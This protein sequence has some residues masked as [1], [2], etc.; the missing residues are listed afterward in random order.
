[1]TTASQNTRLTCAQI[2]G[3]SRAVKLWRD[4]WQ[5]IE[6][7]SPANLVKLC[8]KEVECMAADTPCVAHVRIAW[9]EQLTTK[10][11]ATFLM[12]INEDSG[13]RQKM[14][15]EQIDDY[16]RILTHEYGYLKPQEFM[17]FFLRFKAGYYGEFYDSVDPN[18][19]MK[20]FHR[21]MEWRRDL[22]GKAEAERTRRERQRQ[23]QA[24][25]AAKVTF[26]EYIS[27]RNRKYGTNK[28]P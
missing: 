11:L 14:S 10:W 8:G 28:Q 9:G 3:A 19:I 27:R 7:F 26:E 21:F 1:M 4:E 24:V 2:H 12:R 18:V 6:R 15:I 17:L 22:L 5:F 20:S 23:E 25:S 16:A 13:K